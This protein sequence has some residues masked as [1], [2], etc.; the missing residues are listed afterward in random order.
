MIHSEE[1]LRAVKFMETE[2]REGVTRGWRE[3]FNDTEF[4]SCKTKRVLE[5]GCT[6]V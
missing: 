2:S 4:Q 1:L 6:T 3:L 5:I